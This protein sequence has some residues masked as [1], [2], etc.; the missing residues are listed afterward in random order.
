V[1]TIVWHSKNHVRV[2]F[3]AYA[4]TPPMGRCFDWRAGSHP[5]CNHPHQ[6]F[7]QLVQA[8]WNTDPQNFGIS[9]GLAGRS[10]NSVSTVMLHCDVPVVVYDDVN[11][12]IHSSVKCRCKSVGL[13]LATRATV[14]NVLYNR[15][16]WYKF[17]NTHLYHSR[18]LY[19]IHIN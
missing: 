16:S 11:S 3:N 8:F 18:Q 6:I 15:L 9:I 17:V 1:C 13:P 7:H 19:N 4:E 2:I 10:Y 12:R 14:D 5:R